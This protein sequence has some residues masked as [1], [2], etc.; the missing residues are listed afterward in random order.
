MNLLDTSYLV[1]F[2]LGRPAAERFSRAHEPEPLAVS[3]VSVFQLAFG[4]AWSGA[5]A[6]DDLLSTLE[7]ADR[8]DYSAEDAL[9]SAESR[10]SSSRP[11]AGSQSPTPCSRGWHGTGGPPSS[12][13]TTTSNGST[14]SRCDG[15]GTDR[16]SRL[17]TG[18][19]S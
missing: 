17:P 15:T 13:G 16:W 5:G 2:E 4:L 3:S 18:Y 11:G 1:D 12:P 7:W 19:S 10:P 6:I 14:G 8:L 9:E